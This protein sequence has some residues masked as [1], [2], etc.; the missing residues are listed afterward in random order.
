M[1]GRLGKHS[2]TTVT[3]IVTVSHKCRVT[4]CCFAHT[5]RFTYSHWGLLS[6]PW[7]FWIKL[8]VHRLIQW[9][10]YSLSPTLG[11]GK[12]SY[13]SVLMINWG[14]DG[15]PQPGLPRGPGA[16]LKGGAQT[17]PGQ[18]REGVS[19]VIL[20]KGT[21]AHM[22]PAAAAEKGGHGGGAMHKGGGGVLHPAPSQV[23]N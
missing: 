9:Y 12:D 5:C 4:I 13:T 23:P 18:L 19:M 11:K 16:D 14:P 3:C 1:K 7:G 22:V 15:H 10:H 6:H 17:P 2:I 21:W 20:P 8:K